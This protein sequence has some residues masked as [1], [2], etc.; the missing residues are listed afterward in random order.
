MELIIWIQTRNDRKQYKNKTKDRMHLSVLQPYF[1]PSAHKLTKSIKLF[2]FEMQFVVI[3]YVNNNN[4]HHHLTESPCFW[5]MLT[6][7]IIRH[8]L[9]VGTR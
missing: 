7:A 5:S 3:R 9:C 6:D 2:L 8:S 1:S 4:N